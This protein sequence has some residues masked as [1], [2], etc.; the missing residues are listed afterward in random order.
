MSLLPSYIHENYSYDISVKMIAEYIGI[1]RSYLFKLFRARTGTSVQGYLESYR[2]KMAAKLMR[3]STE[4]ISEICC[5]CGFS[6]TSYFSRAFKGM[7]GV[8]PKKYM[9]MT[10]GESVNTRYDKNAGEMAEME[11]IK[12]EGKLCSDLKYESISVCGRD[13]ELLTQTTG[14]TLE[15][16]YEGHYVKTLNVGGVFTPPEN[17]RLGYVRLTM[18][19]VLEEAYREG[20][21]VSLLHPFDC[22]C[23]RK[24]GYEVLSDHVILDFP[25]SYLSGIEV[26][27]NFRRLDSQNL[28]DV[29]SVYDS[30]S[31]GRSLMFKRTDGYRYSAEDFRFDFAGY[32]NIETYIYYNGGVP[33]GYIIYSGESRFDTNRSVKEYLHVHE[34]AYTSPEALRAL[35]GFVRLFAGEYERVRLENIAMSPEVRML[36]PQQTGMTINVVPDIMGRVLDV[37]KVLELHEYPDT[38]GNFRILLDDSLGCAGVWSVEFEKGKGQVRKLT[39]GAEY[40]VSLT[41]PAFTRIVYGCADG[42]EMFGRAIPGVRVK[43]HSDLFRAFPNRPRGAF[44]HF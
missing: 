26:C 24:F 37:K 43:K 41:M 6:S 15:T 35:L 12:K 39:D 14:S 9:L 1:D 5:S 42:T 34:L 23:Y 38:R 10:E 3:S 27:R 8:P 20:Y 13:G 4:N 31:F 18:E 44:E 19:R 30:F 21:T 11:F 28:A 25:M 40:E 2:L 22:N 36:I 16:R 29:L 7:F 33:E 17:R 32:E